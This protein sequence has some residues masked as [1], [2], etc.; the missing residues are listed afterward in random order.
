MVEDIRRQ[1]RADVRAQAEA[2]AAARSD[3]IGGR[4]SRIRESLFGPRSQES[5]DQLEAYRTQTPI[6]E[7]RR[8]RAAAG[9]SPDTTVT[10]PRI[11]SGRMAVPASMAAEQDNPSSMMSSRMGDAEGSNEAADTLRAA[12]MARRN[13]AARPN[14]R[15]APARQSRAA[16]MSADD[17]NAISLAR[18]EG[19]G[20]AA[21]NIRRRL[22]EMGEGLKK[23]GKVKAKAPVK[24]MKAGGMVKS[25][26]SRGDGVA[27]K[28]K[29]KGRMV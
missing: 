24:K 26:C 7:I 22:A 15:M 18:G 4:L 27:K 9:V 12:Q 16:S 13:Q 21:A 8:R 17:L 25:S 3:R 19:E 28:G 1:S 20:A 11:S 29:T 2:E 14:A 10:A 23:G 5:Q 6:D